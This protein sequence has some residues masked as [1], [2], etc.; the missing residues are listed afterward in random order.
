[1][2]VIWKVAWH[3]FDALKIE[4]NVQKNAAARSE[5]WRPSLEAYIIWGDEQVFESKFPCRLIYGIYKNTFFSLRHWLPVQTL[6][7]KQR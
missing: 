3:I 2:Q 6:T 5:F 7:A 1:M 4:L